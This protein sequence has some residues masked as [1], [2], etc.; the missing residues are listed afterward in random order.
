M[1]NSAIAAFNRAARK[2]GMEDE[3]IEENEHEFTVQ[4]QKENEANNRE[5]FL[6]EYP[7]LGRKLFKDWGIKPGESILELG[8]GGR[9]F[10]G[11]HFVPK[12][13]KRTCLH[14]DIDPEL[15]QASQQIDPRGNYA[16]ADATDLKNIP[17]NFMDRVLVANLF[18]AVPEEVRPQILKE[19]YRVLKPGAYCHSITDLAPKISNKIREKIAEEMEIPID[20][21]CTA[22]HHGPGGLMYRCYEKSPDFL[23]SM[24][25]S[26]EIDPVEFFSQ[27]I[28][29][30][31][32]KE[33][34]DS[35]TSS[36]LL[37]HGL[38]NRINM[39]LG[40]FISNSGAY[41]QNMPKE[42][43]RKIISP[44]KAATHTLHKLR[45]IALTIVHINVGQKKESA[46][47]ISTTQQDFD[48]LEAYK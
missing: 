8:C 1:S 20:D 33:H 25:A 29:T 17:D 32:F 44:E 14:T 48:F 40:L 4:Q 41:K 39:L 38:I 37:H 6:R 9:A 13:H 2:L 35:S 26:I 3:L 42:I 10:L 30:P 46:S 16:V 7:L 31:L 22:E 11:E 5:A 19:I 24:M 15:V 43:A 45:T 28:L 47:Q 36:G 18:N 27:H 34:F 21:F 12:K 23:G